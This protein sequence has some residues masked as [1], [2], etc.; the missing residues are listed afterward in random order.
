LVLRHPIENRSINS[1]RQLSKIYR[2]NTLNCFMLWEMLS[3][4][5]YNVTNI[6]LISKD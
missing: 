4:P 6:D 5:L 2:S 1:P 3:A